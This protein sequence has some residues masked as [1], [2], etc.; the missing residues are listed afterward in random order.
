MLGKRE[1]IILSSFKAGKFKALI[2]K[3]STI[4]PPDYDFKT[5]IPLKIGTTYPH[6]LDCL[7][8]KKSSA[9]ADEVWV[10][11]VGVYADYH[12]FGQVMHDK[13][14]FPS[15]YPTLHPQGYGVVCEKVM[16][17]IVSLYTKY[18]IQIFQV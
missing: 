1:R 10:L 5:W 7:A 17:N 13:M 4:D 3:V 9:M 18:S 2:D 16:K 12:Q 11:E 6:R 8:T 15:I 14:L